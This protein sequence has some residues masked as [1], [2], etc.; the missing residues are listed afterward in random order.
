MKFDNKGLELCGEYR[1]FKKCTTK[2]ILEHQKA[3]EDEQEKFKPISDKATKI[4]NDVKMIDTQI[5]S[6]QNY[7]KAINNKN[8]PSDEEL[9]KVAEYSMEIIELT[10]KRMKLIEKANALDE[11]HKEDIQKLHIYVL[12]KYGELA[13]LQLEITKEEYIQKADNVDATIVRLISSIRKMLLLG[14]SSKDV[15]KFIKQNVNEEAKQSF[16]RN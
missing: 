4:E 12:E 14:S 6:I 11:K 10:K 8:E 1:K 16:R 2:D 7:S 15:E 3:I 5:E 13:E 9:D